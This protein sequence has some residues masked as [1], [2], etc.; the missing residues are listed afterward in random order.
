MA[1]ILPDLVKYIN[2]LI[3]KTQQTPQ[4]INTVSKITSLKCR[5]ARNWGEGYKHNIFIYV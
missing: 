4:R 3:Q 5:V 1:Q 2:L